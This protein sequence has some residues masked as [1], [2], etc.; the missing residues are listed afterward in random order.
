MSK[1]QA[2]RQPL[3][4]L[5]TDSVVT[6]PVYNMQL[7]DC[8]HIAQ[9]LL[10]QA[11]TGTEQVVERDA[12]YYHNHFQT[13]Q[14][15]LGMFDEQ[16]LLVA[17][18]LIRGDKHKTTMLNVLVDPDHRGQKLHSRIIDK[19][20]EVATREGIKS[21]TARVRIDNM[22]SLTNFDKAGMTI[23]KM[24]PSPEAPEHMTYVMTK[25]LQKPLVKNAECRPSC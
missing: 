20:L 22:P 18:A 19:W 7:L 2:Q 21:A 16:G 12:D 17:Q 8:A 10:L 1:R 24:E 9:M 25:S 4:S 13:G 6:A 5:F 15:A 23:S 11:R 3:T 14:S